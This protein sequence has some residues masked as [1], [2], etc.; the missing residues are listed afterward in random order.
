MELL[1]III[2]CLWIF[3]NVI[4]ISYNAVASKRIEKLIDSYNKYNKTIF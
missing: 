1:L 3:G 2:F 4:I